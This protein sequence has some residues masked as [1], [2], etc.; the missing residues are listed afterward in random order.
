MTSLR[1]WLFDPVPAHGLVVLRIGLGGVLFLAYLL[2][3]PWVDALYGPEGFAGY[4]Y[5]Q[6]FPESGPVGWP[7]VQ[8]FDWLQQVPSAAAIWALYLAL[9]LSSLCFAAGVRPKLTGTV[10]LVLHAL[11]LGRNPGATWGWATMMEP[12]LAYAILGSDGRLGS[13]PG[14][15]RRRRGTDA[16]AEDWTLPAWPLR[17]VQ[18]HV[19]CSFL[20]LWSRIDEGSWLSGQMLAVALVGREFSRLDIDWV[21]FLGA[22]ELAGIAALI[23]ELGAPVALWIRP[24]GKY[25]ALAL[26]GMFLVLVCTTSVGWWDFMMLVALATFLPTEWL[27]RFV[28]PPR[29]A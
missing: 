7:G 10:A 29:R 23:L 26:M 27:A 19:A 3:W 24:I 5:F 28:G 4:A 6:R 9:L 13:L 15:L 25:W 11:F 18:V 17:I 2:R 21:P 8:H 12:F 1:R 22:L 20:A 16:E 14:W